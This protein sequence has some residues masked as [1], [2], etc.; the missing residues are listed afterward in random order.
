MGLGPGTC[1]SQGCSTRLM[2]RCLSARLHIRMS[3]MVLIL[4]T[5]WVLLAAPALCV[6]GVLEHFCADCPEGVDCT[7]EESC[8]SDPCEGLL[9]VRPEHQQSN[10]QSAAPAPYLAPDFLTP[11]LALVLG[12]LHVH[13]P[14]SQ[15]PQKSLPRPESDLPLL[16]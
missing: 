11:S 14:T 10:D 3:R 16:I 6:G 2:N 12:P 1:P 7:H 4:S 8:A 9:V 13:D 15:P 5:F